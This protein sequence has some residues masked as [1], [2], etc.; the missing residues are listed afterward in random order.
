MPTSAFSRH[1]QPTLPIPAFKFSGLKFFSC[2]SSSFQFLICLLRRHP[3]PIPAWGKVFLKG[4][5][6][7]RTFGDIA[8][9]LPLPPQPI[10][11]RWRTSSG[12]SGSVSMLKMQYRNPN[13]RICCRI[14][15]RR[16]NWF[17]SY[18][19]PRSYREVGVQLPGM[20]EFTRSKSRFRDRSALPGCETT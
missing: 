2:P 12:K 1:F 18:I 3:G 7:I 5:S 19:D 20:F 13:V 17:T 10:V 15:H 14:R 11:T 4:P 16:L 6:R 9:E 8:P